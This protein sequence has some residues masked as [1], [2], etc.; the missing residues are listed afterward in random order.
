[1]NGKASRNR[2]L[3]DRKIV[4]LWASEPTIMK[5]V[6]PQRSESNPG[7]STYLRPPRKTRSLDF[8]EKDL[9]CSTIFLSRKS[10]NASSACLEGRP[11]ERALSPVARSKPGSLPCLNAR[12]Y[13]STCRVASGHA[14]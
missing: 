11:T 7:N 4:A 2:G 5:M 13:R 1:M 3:V 14:G 12:A 8:T 6:S 10:A 9:R